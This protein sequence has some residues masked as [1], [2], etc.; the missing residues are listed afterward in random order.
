MPL[1]H[2]TPKKSSPLTSSG[3]S[4]SAALRAYFA[5]RQILKLKETATILGLSYSHFYRRVQAGTLNLKVRKNEIGER[6]VLLDDLILYLFPDVTDS[7][8]PPTP[9]KRRPGRPR[10]GAEGGAK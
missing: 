4:G 1:S 9:A 2:S 5:P 3:L 10:K 7:A 8:S 6:F